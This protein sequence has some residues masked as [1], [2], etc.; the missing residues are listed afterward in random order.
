MAENWIEQGESPY[1]YEREALE[2]VRRW[3]PEHEPWRAFARFT[4]PG[5]D[6]RDHE[7]DLLVAGPTGCFL[8]EF[9]GHEGRISGNARDLVSTTGARRSAFDHP[10]PLLKSKLDKLVDALKQTKTYRAKGS[11][12]PFIEPLVFMHHAETLEIASPGHLGVVLRDREGPDGVVVEGLKAAILE[13]RAPWMPPLA[14]GERRVDKPAAKLLTSAIKEIAYFGPRPPMV[15]GS[16]QLDAAPIEEASAWSDFEATHKV[17]GD[18]RTVRVYIAPRGRELE[19]ARLANNAKLEFEALRLFDHPGILRAHELDEC[20]LGFAIAFEHTKGFVRLDH[21]V[22]TRG[23]T[24]D[25]SARLELLRQLCEAVSAAHDR[26][27]AHR[28]LSP[29]SVLVANPDSDR[30]TIKIR[31]WHRRMRTDAVERSALRTFGGETI[32]DVTG[33]SND[34]SEI[35]R[36]YLAPELRAVG[37]PGGIASDIYSLGAL[38]Y[39]IFTGQPPAQTLAELDDVLT[40]QQ[41]LAVSQHING[42]SAGLESFIARAAHASPLKRATTARELI[43]WLDKTQEELARPEFATVAGP[44]DLAKDTVLDGGSGGPITVVRR[45][46][47][48]GTAV[49]FEVRRDDTAFALKVART[50]E[51]NDRLRAEATAL[52]ALKHDNIVTLVGTVDVGACSALLL[53]PF[54]AETLHDYLKRDGALQLDFLERWGTQ[55]LRAVE[56]LEHEGKSHRDIKPGNIAITDRGQKKAQQIVL[57]DF[58]LAGL[59]ADNLQAGTPGYIDPFLGTG[60]RRNWDRAAE[61]YATAVTLYEMATGVRPVWGDGQTLPQLLKDVDHPNLDGDLLPEGVRASLLTFFQ[62]ALHREAAR[63]FDSAVAMREAW[64]KAL[65]GNTVTLVGTGTAEAPTQTLAQ[66]L[67]AAV[68]GAGTD[69]IIPSLPL[70]MRAQNALFRLGVDSVGDLL[71]RSPHSLRWL[72]GVGS[73]TQKELFDLYQEARKRFPEVE[74]TI[75]SLED[76][77]AEATSRRQGAGA[78]RRGA[79]RPPRANASLA[80]DA[81]LEALAKSLLERSREGESRSSE[82]LGDYLG[83]GAAGGD[84]P[85]EPRSMAAAA[86]A[87]GVTRAAVHITIDSA[88]KRWRK[89]DAFNHAAAVVHELLQ[90]RGG[91]ATMHEI[92]AAIATRLPADGAS[93]P[94]QRAR[95]G[96][97]VAL[98]VAEAEKRTE[99][100]PRYELCRTAKRAFIAPHGMSAAA[101]YAVRLGK[102]ADELVDPAR[103]VLPGPAACLAELRT[104]RCPAELPE[105]SNER[106]L[107]LAAASSANA[108]LNGRGELYPRGLD[109]RRA[110]KLSQGALAGLGELERGAQGRSARRVFTLTQLRERVAQRYPE[111]AALP[112]APE[113]VA[114]VREV[115]GSE[116]DFDAANNCFRL[117]A[118]ESMTVQ[119]GSGSRPTMYVTQLGAQPIDAHQQAVNRANDFNREVHSAL[120]DRRVMVLGVQPASFA[121]AVPRLAAHF[122]VRHVSL[123]ALILDGL[124]A[125]AAKRNIQLAKVHEADATWPTGPA[126]GNLRAV[127][128]MVRK[129][130]VEPALLNPGDPI[131][132]SD[133]GLLFRYG[134]QELYT[135]LRDACGSGAH[136]GALAVLPADDAEQSIVLDGFTFPEFNPSRILRVPGAWLRLE[137][138]PAA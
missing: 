74:V 59:A 119:T 6:G 19:R 14:D 17:T 47:S 65:E 115:L 22:L 53:W 48:G 12:P 54:G 103:P 75:R 25:F 70:S 49:G 84:A 16:W 105:L 7:I 114:L 110:L 3:F 136:P 137:T 106:L 125:V 38:A 10:K 129:D 33:A 73:T 93:T 128:E 89:S 134:M 82:A 83:I 23:A 37:E 100:N 45:L 135:V 98:A 131:L 35:E 62:R 78:R 50:A 39:L 29:S 66:A 127:L 51:L 130:H 57:F 120:K 96:F 5:S 88:V 95:A 117:R 28:A 126:S 4:F 104:E 72:Q 55:L 26:G 2:W 85:P 36:T 102:R 71:R 1:P 30:P 116:T 124:R 8:I 58:S 52:A 112:D 69:T 86:E 60:N 15:A 9:K 34:L 91:I 43:E 108:C 20:D 122:K 76:I 67:D 97:A 21:F 92:G 13:R 44:D 132:V 40:R 111:A 18:K 41:H 81:T 94:A 56:H 99:D 68:A 61:R 90:A 79:A 27:I 101:H 24:L 32:S 77:A 113:C 42:A 63:R 133:W 109:A 64:A 87:H 80:A 121:R 123:D 11:R 118:A 31:N 107:A 138:A 46:G